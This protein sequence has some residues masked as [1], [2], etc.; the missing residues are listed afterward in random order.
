MSFD[1]IFNIQR[2][3]EE[4]SDVGYLTRSGPRA[5]R[6]IG[7]YKFFIGFHRSDFGLIC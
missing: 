7:L 1:S 5:R 6:I 2:R 3:R 4:G